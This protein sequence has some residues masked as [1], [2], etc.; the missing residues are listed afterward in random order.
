MSTTE[1]SNP[2]GSEPNPGK[3]GATQPGS[4]NSANSTAPQ[5]STSNQ[6]PTDGP[7]PFDDIEFSWETLRKVSIP[8]P[9]AKVTPADSAHAE[10]QVSPIYGKTQPQAKL[11]NSQAIPDQTR[12][13]H[14]VS[15]EQP[16]QEMQL[17][18]RDLDDLPTQANTVVPQKPDLGSTRMTSRKEYYLGE[19]PTKVSNSDQ[20]S[21]ANPNL[22][23]THPVSP[24]KAATQHMPPV[25]MGSKDA[26]PNRV[27]EVDLG[28]TQV[29]RSAIGSGKLPGSTT[30]PQKAVRFSDTGKGSRGGNG[31]KKGN[32]N[33]NGNGRKKMG[34]GG[35]LV[36]VIIVMLFLVVLALVAAGA[37][38]VYQYFTIAAT[39][40]SV[41]G[42]KA[43]AS[44]FETTRIYDRNGDL[45]YELLDPNA[46][47]RTYV[48]LNQIS[49]YVIAATI[50]TEDKEYYSHP[51]F[52]PL[53]I[54]RA[55]IANYTTGEVVSG[56]ST[57]TQQLARAL[58]MDPNERTEITVRRKAR[59]IILAAE[60]TRRYSKD[61]ILEIYLNE[62]YYGN[63]AYG[64][65]AAAETYFNTTA[66]ALNLEQSAFLAGLPQS[67]ANYDIF[68]NRDTTLYRLKQ[69]LTLMYTDSQ[70][71]GCIYVSTS[72]E[73]ICLEAQQAADAYIAIDS[74]TFTVRENQMVYPHWVNY[75]RY[76]L[77]QNYDAQT[78]YRSGFQVYTTLDPQLQT[79]AER[80]VKEQVDGLADK[81]VTDGALVAIKPSTGEILAMVGSADFY[82]DAIAG[83]INMALKPRQPGSSIKPLTYA[84]AF[85][86]GWTP[87]TLIWDVPSEFP[88]SGNPNDTR[89]PYKPVNYDGKFHGPVTVRT[90]LANSFNIPAVK[91]LDFVGI[92]DDPSTPQADGLINFAKRMGITTLTRDD[93]G[94]SL[95]LGGGEVTLLDMTSA[96][97]VF[98]N[99]GARVEPMAITKITDY[100]G[101]VIYQ[102]P[103]PVAN[104]VLKPEY[105]YLISS[106]L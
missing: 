19:Q 86:K 43:A 13:S 45:L 20:S 14:A 11:P 70:E 33:A 44:Q 25:P 99:S 32:G 47:R 38:L 29:S 83:Q 12:P 42:L 93:Y 40:P 78:I 30:Q 87:A 55:L 104:R 49:P 90:A 97:G 9:L 60:I 106:I 8:D 50:A 17:G 76:L 46:G 52:D 72:P 85:E 95:T 15:R 34:F 68:T 53:A 21:R 39:L 71:K 16:L 105:A 51:G 102:A 58:L 2:A 66:G 28:A 24:S 101:N 94:L 100:S 3:P 56:A 57:I 36:R 10:T 98:A 23:V 5:Q 48:P 18:A 59:E 67:P 35:C 91:T 37:F 26:L 80:I 41:E 103:Q 81:H 22:D 27:D 61:E 73:R 74:Y 69:V 7:V 96:F 79:E 65:Q 64:I 88:P 31:K 89:E 84:A 63:L 54:A 4:P 1:Q 75:I 6:S 92:Y 62:I 82:N 77:E